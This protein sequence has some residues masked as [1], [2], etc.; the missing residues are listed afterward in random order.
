MKLL[1]VTGMSGA[2]KSTVLNL[3]EDAGYFCVDNLPIAL[4]TKFAQLGMSEADTSGRELAIGIDIRGEKA[5]GKLPEALREVEELGVRV[6][7]LFL[8]ASEEMLV[9]RFQET[10]RTHPLAG[11]GRT[12]E[13]IRLEREKINFLA[14]EADYVI[15][16]SDFLVR[17]LKKEIDRLFVDKEE[18]RE[19]YVTVLSFGFKNGIPADADLVFDVRFLPNPYYVE[20]LREKTGDAPEIV[21]FLSRYPQTAEFQERLVSMV[22][23]LLPHY[24]EEG[25][26]RLVIALGCTGGRHRSVAMANALYERLAAEADYAVRIEHRDLPHDVTWQS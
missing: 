7:I 15:D 5:L 26:R 23:F 19:L 16:T 14:E 22:Q 3:L 6:E 17:D 4:L 12:Q 25:K 20:E 11:K 2:G 10:R 21:S 18:E 9:K 1:I 24:A 8:D 13:G